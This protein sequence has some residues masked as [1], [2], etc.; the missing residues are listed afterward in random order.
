MFF[1]L[2]KRF[3]A[4]P[5]GPGQ[6]QRLGVAR[7]R[8]TLGS[9]FIPCRPLGWGLTVILLPTTIY[10]QSQEEKYPLRQSDFPVEKGGMKVVI[11]FKVDEK[12]RASLKKLADKENRSL[13][14]YILTILLKNL[15]EHGI[16]WREETGI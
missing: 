4:F 12:V 3:R 14:N 9:L 7:T 1:S 15:Q 10:Y 6:A 2:P 13:S 5:P 16:D 8:E 11:S